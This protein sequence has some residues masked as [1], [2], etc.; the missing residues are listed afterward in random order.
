MLFLDGATGTNLF[1]KG[2]LPGESPASLNFK[3]PEA[4]YELQKAYIEAGSDIILTNTFSA[5]PLNFKGDKYKEAI[6]AGIE[7]A[8]LA[9]RDKFVFGDVGPLGILI[10]PFG[11]GSF[12][13]VYKIYLEIF[14]AFYKSKV[15]TFFLETFNSMIE[16][17]AAFLAARNYTDNILISFS[18]QDNAK[19]VFGETP[20][21]I[22]VTFERLGAKAVGV[23][24]TPPETAIEVIKRMAS[25][26]FLPLI[27]KPNA[28]RVTIAGKKVRH[29]IS[30]QN[31]ARYFGDFIQAGASIIGGCCGT[32]PDYITFLKKEKAELDKIKTRTVVKL[33]T[34]GQRTSDERFLLASPQGILEIKRDTQVIVGERL[35]PSGR[36]KIRERLLAKDYT[37]YG[38]EARLQEEAG[39]RALDINAFVPGLDE[40]E[41]LV[42][43]LTEVIRN[44]K[45]SVFIDSQDFLAA[46]KAMEIYPGIGVYNSIP[47]RASE[48][49]KF[50]P[51]VRYYG[52]KAVI[53][54]LGKKIPRT[55]QERLKNA[56]LA[57]KIA[58]SLK[59]P[60]SDL[61][62]DPLVFSIATEPKQI[63]ETLKA[64]SELRKRG[65]KTILGISN[66]S[67]G[68]PE[69]S[70]L[71]AGFVN[72]AIKSGVN[73]LILNP[74][75]S[76]VIESYYTARALFKNEIAEYMR[77]TENRK[78][79]SAEVSRKFPAG[80]KGESKLQLG[81]PAENLIR[82]IVEGDI[83]SATGYTKILLT[84]GISP[85]T[86]IDN[87]IFNAMKKVGDN[88]EKG[89]SFIPDLLKSAEA[90]RMVLA[91]V[92]KGIRKR[93]R[94]TEGRA[95]KRIVLATVKGDIH[96]IGK[97]I[98]AMILES[99]GYEVI[100]LGKDVSALKIVKAVKRY[101][102]VAVGLSA[103]LTT[104]MLEMENVIKLMK[105]KGIN[106]P[107][108]IGG[109][110]VSA[111]FAK[112]IGAYAGVNNAFEGLRVLKKLDK[113]N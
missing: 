95:R 71:N 88:Y 58:R 70:L 34:I 52:F 41:T 43:C 49:K 101:K 3:K 105:E 109:P 46:K 100:D 59:F 78:V 42:N 112:K 23:N 108:I 27:A 20:E 25:A 83:K 33:K 103:L 39:A 102:P 15:R 87:Y 80:P 32:T 4:V 26:T 13:E 22:A 18:F 69:R 1:K 5:N 10:R 14:A 36:K 68:L 66:V 82:A 7:I 37:I 61:I 45:L 86:I 99:A 2:L 19:T 84:S 77:W 31:L 96:D 98:V 65:L 64:V 57:I 40:R 79:G 91:I 62:F 60:V 90:T 107:V 55:W 44:S 97:N 9:G 81:K 74:L 16:A 111:G 21:S 76:R 35:N 53:S 11:E 106:T 93:E 73:F 92:K 8:R 29:T 38:E 113:E 6:K 54:L 47:A 72:L 67:F 85:E 56:E 110:N 30:D 24:C 12:D 75:D 50:L 104:T 94:G 17:K 89:I 28:G 48:L 51:L 63:E